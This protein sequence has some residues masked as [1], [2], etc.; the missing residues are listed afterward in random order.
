MLAEQVGAVD[1][2]RIGE[3]VAVVTPEEA[4]GIDEA[5]EDCPEVALMLA[6][7][8]PVRRCPSRR[9]ISTTP[10]YCLY[11]ASPILPHR[12]LVTCEDAGEQA[13]E[14][15]LLCKQG[16]TGSSPVVSTE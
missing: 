5:L 8:L 11:I 2:S 15:V 14:P 12:S 6:S 13:A 10:L 1:A 3:L 16:A 7:S 9:A 4:W